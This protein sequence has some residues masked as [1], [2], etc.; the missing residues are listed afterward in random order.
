MAQLS[1]RTTPRQTCFWPTSQGMPSDMGGTWSS[2]E[3]GP[4]GV[5]SVFSFVGIGTRRPD[6]RHKPDNNRGA[7][8][9]IRAKS[10]RSH[11]G[12]SRLATLLEDPQAGGVGQPNDQG[13]LGAVRSPH[14]MGASGVAARL[15]VVLALSPLRDSCDDRANFVGHTA[16]RSCRCESL[17]GGCLGSRYCGDSGVLAMKVGP[18]AVDMIPATMVMM[19]SWTHWTR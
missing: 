4:C 13:G 5:L 19:R 11:F 9:H 12:S 15:V 8:K 7:G 17:I 16:L 6:L 2:W 1:V 18:E 3:V 14:T 10:V